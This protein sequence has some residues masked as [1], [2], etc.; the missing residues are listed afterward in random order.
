MPRAAA[1][2]WRV[3]YVIGELGKGGAE[4]QLYELLCGL[5]RARFCAQVFVLSAGGSWTGLIRGLGLPVLELAGRGSA[6]LGRLRRLRAALRTFEP[7][8]LHTVLWSGSSYGR[9]AAAGMHVPVVITA[10]RNVIARPRWQVS[11]E[12]L[13]DRWTDLYLVNSRAIADGLV[14]RERLPPA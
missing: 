13:L 11:F 6:D 2:A 4:Y 3:A 8:V 12:R 1:A 7:H 9:L 5:D 14:E 10:E